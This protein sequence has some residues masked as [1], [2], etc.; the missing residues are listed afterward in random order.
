MKSIINTL[1]TSL[2]LQ[3]LISMTLIIQIIKMRY[4][5]IKQINKI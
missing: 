3:L 2:I 4:L 5:T 1:I